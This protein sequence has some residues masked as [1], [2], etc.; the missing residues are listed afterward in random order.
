M[1]FTILL[2]LVFTLVTV[3]AKDAAAPPGSVPMKVI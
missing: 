2:S 3:N 1:I